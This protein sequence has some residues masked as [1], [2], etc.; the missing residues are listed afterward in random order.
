MLLLD[1]TA[2]PTNIAE[3]KPRSGPFLREVVLRNFKTRLAQIIKKYLSS[4]T[5]C[6]LLRVLPAPGAAAEG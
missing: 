6:S 1:Y 2:L 5:Q 3:I 4:L